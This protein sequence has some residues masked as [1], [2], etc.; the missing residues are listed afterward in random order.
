MTV[1][2]LIFS[3][4][5]RRS[6]APS[7]APALESEAPVIPRRRIAGVPPAGSGRVSPGDQ[8]PG[9]ETHPVIGVQKD[10]QMGRL[11][12][13]KE[14]THAKYKAS[15]PTHDVVCPIMAGPH[16]HAGVHATRLLP[17]TL[18]LLCIRVGRGVASEIVVSTGDRQDVGIH[19]GGGDRRRGHSHTARTYSSSTI[20]PFVKV[21]CS[22]GDQGRGQL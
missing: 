20:K 13:T 17:T 10:G 11:F 12:G 7:R 21:K 16:T 4:S 5:A 3:W 18:I 19:H 1:R 8:V 22:E 6:S 14:P 2:A 9:G 15:S